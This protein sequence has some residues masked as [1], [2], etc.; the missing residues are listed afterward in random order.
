[1]IKYDIDPKLKIKKLDELMDLPMVLLVNKFD[2]ASAKE[3][4]N[5]FAKALNTGQK[6]VP[7]V[8]DSPGGAVYS[9]LSMVGVI[10]SSPV[11][12]ATICCGKAMS[13]GAILL[14]CGTEGMRF[15]DPYATVMVHEAASHTGGKVSEIKADVKE[16]ERLNQL[17][18][19]LMATNIGKPE[20]YFAKIIHEKSHADLFWNADEAK[21]NNL[22]NHIRVPNFTVKVSTDISFG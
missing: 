17:I 7:I 15:I 11:P 6:I 8:I 9:L 1:M 10:K 16:T 21:S 13:A 18:L 12:V 5:D 14:S 19:T 22:I 4:R 2:D 3:F 20:D